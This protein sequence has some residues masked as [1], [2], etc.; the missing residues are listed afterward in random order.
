MIAGRLAQHDRRR[1]GGTSDLCCE[2]VVRF[3]VE[4][5]PGYPNVAAIVA[6]DGREF[7]LMTDRADGNC[8]FQ[9]G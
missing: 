5:D 2:Q 8:I 7:I 4:R 1:S 3:T 6:S 9:C